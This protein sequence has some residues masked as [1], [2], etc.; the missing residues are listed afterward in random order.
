MWMNDDYYDELVR[1]LNSFAKDRVNF[2][3]QRFEPFKSKKYRQLTNLLKDIK[4]NT[5]ANI[6][7]ETAIKSSI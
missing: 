5:K 2:D 3:E 7:K 4:G 6:T 1:V